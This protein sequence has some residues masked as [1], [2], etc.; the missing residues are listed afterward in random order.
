[1]SVRRTSFCTPVQIYWQDRFKKFRQLFIITRD[2]SFHICWARR[3]RSTLA[4]SAPIGC[5]ITRFYIEAG[6]IGQT[7]EPCCN[8]R[9]L[10]RQS[11]QSHGV[12][13][14]L[15]LL[16]QLHGRARQRYKELPGLRLTEYEMFF[17]V[18]PCVFS[19]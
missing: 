11:L 13:S 15:L 5:D 12:S 17:I 9:R 2:R 4:R 19:T 16:R 6:C 7:I 14:R 1:M 3:D 10:G 18:S 8:G